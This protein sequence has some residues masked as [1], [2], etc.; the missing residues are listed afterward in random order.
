MAEDR[1]KA[2]SK[3][4][5]NIAKCSYG[6]SEKNVVCAKEKYIYSGEQIQPTLNVG[7][8]CSF[9]RNAKFFFGANYLLSI[10]GLFEK[11]SFYVFLYTLRTILYFYNTNVIISLVR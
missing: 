5:V 11:G 3:T 7:N 6:I 10:V 4:V 9:G 2:A 1:Q 8:F